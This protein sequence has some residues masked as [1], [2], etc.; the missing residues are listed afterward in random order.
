[1]SKL[2]E[3]HVYTMGTRTYADE[4]CKVIDPDGK[5][6]GGRILSRDESGSMS[7]KSL[8][9]LFPTDQ[10]MVVVIDDRADVWGD[11]PNLV[12]V[13]PY[14]FF[15]GIGDIN[16]AFLPPTQP[17]VSKMPAMNK[18]GTTAAPDTP[19]TAAS[20]PPPETPPEIPSQEEGLKL[21]SKLLDQLAEDRP[22]AKLEEDREREEDEEAAKSE[23]GGEAQAGDK[24]DGEKSDTP[25]ASQDKDA[26]TKMDGVVETNKT[27]PNGDASGAKPAPEAA[28]P[29]HHN[30]HLRKQLLNPDDYELDRVAGVS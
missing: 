17:V 29:I 11:C 18:D 15:V 27:T 12:K 14:D 7:S 2:Y 21:Q 6:F 26:D 28:T 4:I 24:A 22:L 25:E 30:Y 16:G 3:M 9:R 23:A 10:S 1:M 13:V 8:V 20:S 5:I 19:S